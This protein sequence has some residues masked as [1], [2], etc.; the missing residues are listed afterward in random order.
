MFAARDDELIVRDDE[1]VPPEA[2][3]GDHMDMDGHGVVEFVSSDAA[4]REIT[5][6][7]TGLWSRDADA[8]CSGSVC[9]DIL[10][11]I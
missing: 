5:W 1:L 4:E 11:S 10:Y 3:E 8:T 6:M 9:Q 2:V 7:G